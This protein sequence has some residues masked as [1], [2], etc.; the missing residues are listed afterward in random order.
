LLCPRS[1]SLLAIHISFQDHLN[2]QIK[3]Y[4]HS[5]ME[6]PTTWQAF[7]A[8]YIDKERHDDYKS[9]LAE[10]S[11][12]WAETK[13]LRDAIPQDP[14]W[15]TVAATQMQAR[16]DADVASRAALAAAAGGIVAPGGPTVDPGETDGTATLLA[17]GGGEDLDPTIRPTESADS[18]WRGGW[19][20]GGRDPNTANIWLRL[21]AQNIVVDRRVVKDTQV[22]PHAW[23]DFT[24][25]TGPD[26]RDLQNREHVDYTIQRRLCDIPLG[27]ENFARVR[28]YRNMPENRMYRVVQ[29]YCDGGDMAELRRIHMAGISEPLV[30]RILEQLAKSAIVSFARAF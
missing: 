5:R 29:D 9:A 23:V 27:G 16:I 28:G 14:A 20:L 10:V 30:W 15:R 26:P 24:R 6:V 11:A 17:G 3:T 13:L 19:K 12:G 25:W 4:F 18:L 1:L 7:R 2:P 21:N 22:M 8:R